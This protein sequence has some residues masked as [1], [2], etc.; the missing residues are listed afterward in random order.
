MISVEEALARVLT[1]APAPTIETVPLINAHRRV[2]LEPAISSRAQPPFDASAMDGYAVQGDPEPGAT[3]DV[4]GHAQAGGA[5]A[6]RVGPSQAVRIFTGAPMP[7]GATRVMLQENVSRDGDRVTLQEPNGSGTHIRHK[8]VDFDQGFT[9]SAPR[10]LSATDLSLLA[11][12]NAP[13]VRVARRPSLAIISTGD[14][15]VYPGETPG[16]DQI[17]ASN[18]FAIKALAEDVGADVHALPIAR[19]KPEA[20][21]DV[22]DLASA[23]DVIVTI[24]GVSVGDHDLV[25]GVAQDRGLVPVFHKVAL[26]PGKPILAGR[27]GASVFMGLPGNPVSAITCTHLFLLPLLRRMQGLQ[28]QALRYH[29]AQLTV[30]IAANG[31]RAHFMRAVLS[32]GAGG[33]EITPASSQDSALLSSL[34]QSNALILRPVGDAARAAGDWVDYLNL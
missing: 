1:L 11:A 20:L 15:L 19:D 12:M 24:G 27:L 22:L 16:A 2:L 31:P 10:L 26:R 34:A 14:E 6:G 18:L 21:G 17:I 32:Q 9:L 28:D 8:G 29:R 30:D 33:P 13:E 5:F 7:A 25:A 23:F 3:F 4:I